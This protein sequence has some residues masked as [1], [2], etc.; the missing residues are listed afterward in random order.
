MAA[1]EPDDKDKAAAMELD[2]LLRIMARLRDPLSG[3]PW[4]QKQ[5]FATIAPYTVEEAHEVADAIARGDMD[6]L[7]DELGDLLLQVVYHARIAEEAGLFAF[8]EVAEGI[9]DKMIRRHPHVFGDGKPAQP[10]QWES[11]KQAERK[12]K[13]GD[14][15]AAASLFEGIPAGLPA[16]LR[17]AKLQRRAALLGFDWPSIAPILDKVDEELAELKAEIAAPEDGGKNRRQFEE[18]GDLMFVMVNLGLRLGIDAES[19]LRAANVKFTRRM[20][21]MEQAA[22]QE[23]VTLQGMTLEKM[24][25]F[26]DCAKAA[27]RRG[28][29]G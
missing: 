23:G 8:P 11:I 17:S 13:N 25:V 29:A 7:K 18:F 24:Q 10:G 12:A 27:E 9:C 21:T 28:K 5:T 6:N 22:S 2:R 4:D 19:A 14:G 20:E 15:A 3:C 16:L 26:W 1:V